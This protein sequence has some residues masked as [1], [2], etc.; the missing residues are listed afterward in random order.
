MHEVKGELVFSATEH[1]RRNV[2]VC[3]G[4]NQKC[5]HESKGKWS[6]CDGLLDNAVY[7]LIVM[8]SY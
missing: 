2:G 5:V 7:S 1:T 4:G 3:A 8:M 6:V